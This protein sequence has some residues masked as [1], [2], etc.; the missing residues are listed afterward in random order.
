MA[1]FPTPYNV[2]RGD[3]RND[4]GKH[5]E[6]GADKVEIEG[7]ADRLLKHRVHLK[8]LRPLFS[9]IFAHEQ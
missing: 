6:A 4:K 8:H 1:F 3:Y 9:T 5:I 2:V 7:R